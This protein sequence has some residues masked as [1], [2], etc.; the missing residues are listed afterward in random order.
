MQIKKYLYIFFPLF[1][2]AI[3]LIKPSE[4]FGLV[5]CDSG[6]CKTYCDTGDCEGSNP[7]T[8]AKNGPGDCPSQ[9]GGSS[10]QCSSDCGSI[11]AWTKWEAACSRVDAEVCSWMWHYSSQICSTADKCLVPETA[12]RAGYCDCSYG[13]FYKYCCD[14][15][16][17]PE[18]CIVVAGDG[19]DPPEGECPGGYLIDGDRVR[20]SPCTG[21]LPTTPPG[22]PTPP[23]GGGSC[24]QS[25]GTCGYRNPDG[26]CRSDSGCCHKGCSNGSCITVFGSGYDQCQTNEDCQDCEITDIEDPEWPQAYFPDHPILDYEPKRAIWENTRNNECGG[27]CCSSYNRSFLF[28]VLEKRWDGS[29]DKSAC[30][31][32][33]TRYEE[34]VAYYKEIATDEIFRNDGSGLTGR[35][36][37]SEGRSKYYW[38]VPSVYV[39][40]R[41][42]D[43]SRPTFELGK[44][45]KFCVKDKNCR[46]PG[47]EFL[48][49]SEHWECSGE[50]T[51]TA[52]CTIQGY[53]RMMPGNINT[54]PASTQTVTCVGNGN[55]YS[56]S[57]NPYFFTNIP[58]GN[59]TCSV[60][61]PAGHTVGSTLC[62]NDINC[63]NDAPVMGAS[64]SFSCPAYG[65]A[66]LWWHYY[67]PPTPTPTPYVT[68][69][70]R[71]PSGA[72]VSHSVSRAGWNCPTN[73]TGGY[74]E[75]ETTST[76]VR[77]PVTSYV[78]RGARIGPYSATEIFLGVTPSP[79]SGFSSWSRSDGSTYYG[80]SDWITGGREMT[81]VITSP[82]PTPTNTPTP[83]PT[84]APPSQPTCNQ[85]CDSSP[86]TTVSDR[87]VTLRWSAPSSW[88]TP[89]YCTA[90]RTFELFNGTTVSPLPS[91]PI[92][93]VLPYT[94]T[95]YVLSDQSDGT[96][97]W[98]VKANNLTKFTYSGVCSYTIRYNRD[99]WWQTG[100][101]DV[102][103]QGS[104]TSSIPD[105]CSG[106]CSPYLSLAGSGGDPGVAS[107]GSSV[108]TGEG[109]SISAN[110]W[111]ANTSFGT[112]TGF[113]YLANK[114]EIDKTNDFSGNIDLGA[115]ANGT[116]YSSQGRSLSG[117]VNGKKIVVF[118]NGD[119]TVTSNI[120]V[121]VGGFLAIISSG[122]ITFNSS[123]TAAEGFF[124]ADNA[125]TVAAG[126]SAFRGEGSFIAR[127]GG[128]I[129]FGR[130]LGGATNR[131]TPS[132]LFVSRPDLYVN[133]PREFLIGPSLFRELAP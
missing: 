33:A 132:E 87:T 49:T 7:G 11:P 41:H 99:P 71:S 57:S 119:V 106:G 35:Y 117:N 103:A 54:T 123:V 36:C 60:S 2:L 5:Y 88:G 53:K 95:S 58:Y 10:S 8:C 84:C 107:Y 70:F 76:Y 65:Y 124:L 121:D 26:S 1:F 126:S 133:A 128:G 109:G 59:Y 96:Y 19:M 47:S 116:Y 73:T 111:Q 127:S 44:T 92:N 17:N 61:V 77:D 38:D 120:N 21:P 40:P 14:A 104:I 50:V 45:Y 101:G 4:V 3:F 32:E 52:S 74:N 115:L 12:L 27:N 83:T 75:T 30:D 86:C 108:D 22:E 24:D 80:W 93:G 129:S 23:S 113:D 90:T 98:R 6:V 130:D 31:T 122:S 112:T 39:N 48:L 15:N 55:T 42:S 97:Y 16:G 29:Y 51:V 18:G 118:V 82:T 34:G 56:S 43:Q 125:I 68:V 110:N 102:H 9:C 72:S 78:C 37:P 62:L 131:T 63:H 85:Q 69:R 114:L 13:G 66:D 25:C 81:I 67:A 105:T 89:S 28:C 91:N 64:R 100:D 79:S 94:T 20:S 46:P